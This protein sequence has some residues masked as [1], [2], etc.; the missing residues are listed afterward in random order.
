MLIRED[1][2]MHDHSSHSSY[3][4]ADKSMLER[5]EKD[6]DTTYHYALEFMK[7]AVVGVAALL[8]LMAFFLI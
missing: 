3:T 7:W 4:P 1:A 5:L 8:F 2:F 6:R